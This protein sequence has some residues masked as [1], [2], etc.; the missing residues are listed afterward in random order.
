MG[1][2]ILIVTALGLF[3]MSVKAAQRSYP[4]ELLIETILSA[5]NQTNCTIE[6]HL[7]P[8]KPST[9]VFKWL[10]ARSTAKAKYVISIT[11]QRTHQ[12][13]NLDLSHAQVEISDE[14]SFVINVQN[15]LPVL[16]NFD[17]EVQTLS[18]IIVMDDES[19]PTGTTESAFTCEPAEEI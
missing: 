9:L 15:Q 10:Q 14:G 1:R 11:N 17:P 5:D 2:V 8:Q 12:R 19:H 4:I 13:L 16:L 18:N 7:G 3:S 6:A